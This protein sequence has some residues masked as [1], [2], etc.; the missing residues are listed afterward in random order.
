MTNQF[1]ITII[2]NLNAVIKTFIVQQTYFSFKIIIRLTITIKGK[3]TD[4]KNV[5]NIVHI[6]FYSLALITDFNGNGKRL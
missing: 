1:K 3:H 2:I 6:I 4:V 5:L